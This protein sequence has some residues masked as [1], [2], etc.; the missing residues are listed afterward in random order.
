MA[1]ESKTGVATTQ[2][3]EVYIRAS[4]QSIWDAI[5][6]PE[7]TV[8]YGYRGAIDY[9]LRPGGAYKAHST[10]EMK[11]VGMPDVVVDGTVE[12]A[13]PPRKLVHTYRFLFSDEIKAEGFTRVTWEIEKV[14]ANFSRLTV[15]HELEGA[16]IMAQMVSSKFSEMGGGGWAWILSDLKSMLETG[17]SM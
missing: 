17:N 14:S 4:Q 3:Y 1:T 7:W 10:P 5:T 15:V 6:S 8:K 16:P 11:A 12:Q 13:D 9:D 2:V